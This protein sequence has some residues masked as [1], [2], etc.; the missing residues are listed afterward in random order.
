MMTRWVLLAVPLAA[1]ACGVF[2]PQMC[3][4]NV[5]PGITVLIVDSVSGEPR[6]A[7]AVPV[8]RERAFVDTL[9]PA[10]I[11]GNVLISRQGAHERRG[12]YDV[13][14]RAPGYLDWVR[15]RVI[16]TTVT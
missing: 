8:A 6:A 2:D 13:V 15:T 5:V 14:V 1:G 4:A 9:E 7:E 10:V 3:S 11:R 16:V 12:I